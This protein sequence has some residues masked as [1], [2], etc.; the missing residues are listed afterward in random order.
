MALYEIFYTNP[1]VTLIWYETFENNFDFVYPLRP[2]FKPC[3]SYEC[4][5]IY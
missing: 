3:I 1:P 4:Y 2:T 5:M